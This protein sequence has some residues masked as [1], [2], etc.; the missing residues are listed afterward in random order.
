MEHSEPP[1]SGS[2]RS[3]SRPGPEGHGGGLGPRAPLFAHR[4]TSR[5]WSQCSTR[6]RMPGP[7]TRRCDPPLLPGNPLN[8]RCSSQS[9]FQTAVLWYAKLFSITSPDRPTM[10]L[11]RD[12]PSKQACRSPHVGR[13]SRFEAHPPSNRSVSVRS[14]PSVSLE[15]LRHEMTAMTIRVFS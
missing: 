13:V 9:Q 7:L 11:T 3:F 1:G 2:S 4:K 15:C 8:S 10:V 14:A 12:E 5:L 6:H